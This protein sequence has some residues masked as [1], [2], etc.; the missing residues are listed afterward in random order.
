[1]ARGQRRMRRRNRQDGAALYM[2]LHRRKPCKNRPAIERGVCIQT[3]DN[4]DTLFYD[5][6][7]RSW[8]R[9]CEL[10]SES[11]VTSRPGR[12]GTT[13][14]SR[15]ACPALRRSA[16]D[17]PGMRL[18][19]C[20]RP[21][22]PP[23]RRRKHRL[24]NGESGSRWTGPAPRRAACAERQNAVRRASMEALLLPGTR[25]RVLRW[26]SLSFSIYRS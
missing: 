23:R 14:S 10:T 8:R 4:D 16:L 20:S 6:L 18:D 12:A 24:R 25:R 17:E 11:T 1:M 7:Y 19:R 26:H 22:R 21:E 13:R 5:V 3:R 9:R 15:R 2:L